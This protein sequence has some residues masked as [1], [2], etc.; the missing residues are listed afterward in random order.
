MTFLYIDDC[1]VRWCCTDVAAVVRLLHC[2]GAVEIQRKGLE[3][4]LVVF[5]M[6]RPHAPTHTEAPIAAVRLLD[7][8]LLLLYHNCHNV[9]DSLRCDTST[10]QQVAYSKNKEELNCTTLLDS[11]FVPGS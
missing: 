8:R 7:V 1:E 11:V 10:Q 2:A 5:R 3:S 6:A 4:S 9:E